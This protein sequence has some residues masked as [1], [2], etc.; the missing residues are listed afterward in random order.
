MQSGRARCI[1]ETVPAT[2]R[3]YSPRLSRAPDKSAFLFH[4]SA[5]PPPLRHASSLFL[6]ITTLARAPLAR[7]VTD[8]P[9]WRR[10][11]CSYVAEEISRNEN[12][13]RAYARACTEGIRVVQRVFARALIKLQLKR[14][15]VHE[16]DVIFH[17][18]ADPRALFDALRLA[19]KCVP[20]SPLAVTARVVRV[21]NRKSWSDI[22]MQDRVSALR[23]VYKCTNKYYAIRIS[24]TIR[25]MNFH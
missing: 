6:I 14:P 7:R 5:S 9:L 21:A 11:L 17:R 22:A 16:P 3:R 1:L 25:D 20:C 12:L 4:F 18:Y 24:R 13:A 23:Q 2:L 10:Y 19:R 15:A 8:I